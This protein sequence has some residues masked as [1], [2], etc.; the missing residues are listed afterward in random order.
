MSS[1]PTASAG[2]GTPSEGAVAE[3]SKALITVVVLCFGGLTASLVQT[4]V[5]P[6]QGRLPLLLH[7]SAAN[8]S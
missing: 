6:I 7:T 8:A 5:I 4:L 3:P 1:A 2:A